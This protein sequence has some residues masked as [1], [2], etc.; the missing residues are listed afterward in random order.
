MTDANSVFEAFLPYA[1]LERGQSVGTFRL[2]RMRALCDLAGHPEASFRSVHV[3]G[4]KGKGSVSAML[5]SVIAA[6]G[7]R[8]G[9]YTS[10]HV[11]EFK[12]RIQVVGEEIPDSAFLECGERI[13]R[14]L[15]D[16]EK[17]SHAELGP[18]T[19]FELVTLLSFMVFRE[20]RCEWAV[21]EVGLGGRLDSTNVIL[22]EAS[23]LTA[24]ELEHTEYLG[25]TI[26]DIAFEK[27]GIIKPGRAAFAGKM[28]SE[29]LEVMRRR[30]EE[31]GSPFVYAPER[32]RVESAAPTPRGMVA[33]L[34]L[35][36]RAGAERRLD[37]SLRLSG[38]IQAE[39]AA[40]AACVA[41]E[42]F[43]GI[44]DDALIGGLDRATV[45]ARFQLLSEDPPVVADGAHTPDSAAL[46]LETWL[47]LYGPGGTLVFGCAADKDSK[48]MAS[49]LADSFD[50][51]IVTAPGSF[52][53]S[54]PI[55]AFEDFR[56]GS[57]TLVLEP[58]TRRA[59]KLAR[60]KGE[61][62]LITGSFY[63]AAEAIK[64]FTGR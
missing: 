2:D 6:Q 37:L 25:H 64:L 26:P 22:P 28:R 61:K 33:S 21:I 3:A 14:F 36:D 53:K 30:A 34:V 55:G 59:L 63:L 10:P 5:A 45:P 56:S 48:A 58:D 35:V 54:S 23:V 24:I 18:P 39:N 7:F 17:S 32:S 12:E 52:K 41:V 4:S 15:S 43:P 46:C 40:L 44:G 11:I 27:A 49:I 9:L 20:R 51:V 19:F 42:L 31:L 50:R 13:A 16:W 47:A 38:R 8:V 62:T 57:R 29:A 1:N 60:E